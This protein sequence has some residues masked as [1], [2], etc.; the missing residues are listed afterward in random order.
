MK[1]GKFGKFGK[2]E[3]LGTGTGDWSPTGI[4]IWALGGAAGAHTDKGILAYG[5]WLSSWASAV[6]K[7]RRSQR[8]S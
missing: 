4:G 8:A 2:F 1:F 6:V 5:L 7:C 3:N